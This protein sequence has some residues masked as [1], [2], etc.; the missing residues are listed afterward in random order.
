M[1]TQYFLR[2]HLVN[3]FLES[4]RPYKNKSLEP[5]AVKEL[6]GYQWPGNVRELKRIVEQLCL[7]SP[8]PI[9]RATDVRTLLEPSSKS[10][11]SLDSF[12]VDDSYSL[13]AGL[14]TALK[15]V[16]KK[17]IETAMK[18]FHSDIDETAKYLK[19]SRS[20]LYKK[21]KDLKLTES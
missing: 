1:E 6:K 3:H 17:M 20:N 18:Q 14:E 4:E 16:E 2:Y 7:V 13:E 8:L 21:I 12:M 15:A 10:S 19:V 11:A 5:E 9:I